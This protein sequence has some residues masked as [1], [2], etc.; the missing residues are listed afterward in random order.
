MADVNERFKLLCRI[1][2]LVFDGLSSRK[3]LLLVEVL[4]FLIWVR[5]ADMGR[6]ELL[7]S[8]NNL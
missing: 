3:N 8:L 6:N 4:A 1:N 7:C 5:V 2:R